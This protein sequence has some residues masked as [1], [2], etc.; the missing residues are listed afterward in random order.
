MRHFF[1]I[2]PALI[3]DVADGFHAEMFLSFRY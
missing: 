3:D 2:T 1:I